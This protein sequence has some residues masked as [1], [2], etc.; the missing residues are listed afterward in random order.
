MEYLIGIDLGGTKTEIVL[1]EK[2]TMAV[3]DR[4]R[5]STNAY[6][7]YDQIVINIKELVER[8]E[9]SHSIKLSHIGIGTPGTIDKATSLMKNCNTTCLNGRNLKRDLEIAL[10]KQ[11]NISNDAN[12]FAIAEEKMGAAH[13]LNAAVVIGLIMGTGTGSGIVV[14][15]KILSGLHGI[16]GE[17]G[18]N[19]LDMSGGD[20]YCGNQGCVEMVISGPALERF[21][22]SK[23]G[24]VK[25]M[26]EIVEAYRNNSD[27][28]ATETMLRLFKYFG[29][30]VA[31]LVNI[32]DPDII[33]IGGGLGNI[34][35]LYILGRDEVKKH[36]FNKELN[37]IFIKP[38][39]GDSAGVFG[40]ALL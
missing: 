3:I 17:W 31:V 18:H 16:G 39:L 24:V 38:T 30:A 23:T 19:Y 12:C 32:L 26:D 29:K 33:I 35:E 5:I 37:T 25:R 15:G 21:Y 9:Q 40:A 34:D 4:H 22:Q 7:G 36:V 8:I 1:L 20:C 27:N 2:L 6:L 13:R 10:G 11:V 14:N 28:Y